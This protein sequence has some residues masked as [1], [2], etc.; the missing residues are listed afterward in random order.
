MTNDRREG[1][2]I[3]EGLL[4]LQSFFSTQ[5]INV[6]IMLNPTQMPFMVQSISCSC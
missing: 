2:N 5:Y 4:T 6:N 1:I 3:H